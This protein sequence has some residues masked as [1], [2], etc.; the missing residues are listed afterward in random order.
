MAFHTGE[1]PQQVEETTAQALERYVPQ[2]NKAFKQM[3]ETS[4]ELSSKERFPQGESFEYFDKMCIGLPFIITSEIVF[5]TE[6][7]KDF[8]DKNG[9]RRQ[10]GERLVAQLT[11]RFIDTQTGKLSDVKQAKW[12]GTYLVNQLKRLTTNE[13]FSRVWTLARNP[14][15]PA[16]PYGYPVMLATYMHGVDTPENPEEDVVYEAQHHTTPQPHMNGLSN[17]ERAGVAR[18]Q[19]HAV[20]ARVHANQA[21]IQAAIDADMQERERALGKAKQGQTIAEGLS[22][23][24]SDD[25]ED[26]DEDDGGP[27]PLPENLPA[28]RGP[29]RPPKKRQ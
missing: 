4:I 7:A 2:S 10:I 29:G 11:I 27:L 8:T 15:F 3:W 28:K 14:M 12:G 24:F 17:G 21:A 1:I 22:A 16:T 19:Q 25:D 6:K 13:L 20:S 5:R 26:E 23:L 9:A 18:N